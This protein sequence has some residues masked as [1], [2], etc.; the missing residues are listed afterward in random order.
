[1][2]RDTSSLRS[3]AAAAG[4]ALILFGAWHSWR[5]FRQQRLAGSRSERLLLAQ[6]WADSL[7][8]SSDSLC[9]RDG[10]DTLVHPDPIGW[11]PRGVGFPLRARGLH[12]SWAFG[13]L[14]LPDSGMVLF[15]A[16]DSGCGRYSGDGLWSH[17]CGVVHQVWDLRTDQGSSRVTTSHSRSR[18]VHPGPARICPGSPRP[19]APP[20]SLVTSLCMGGSRR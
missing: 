8:F 5:V 7:D 18:W 15:A 6:R 3:F 10:S 2:D 11:L 17:S 14:Q 12:E 1:M 16:I 20:E 4:I 19:E 13:C 9:A